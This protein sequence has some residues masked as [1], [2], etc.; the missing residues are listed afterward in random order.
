MAGLELSGGRVALAGLAGTLLSSDDLGQTFR[1]RPQS[2]RKGN[3][4]L[5]GAAESLVLFGEGG[6]RP[7][8][9]AR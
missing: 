3:V 9:N 7:V 1:T 8:E 6:A 2:D 5:L 4:A